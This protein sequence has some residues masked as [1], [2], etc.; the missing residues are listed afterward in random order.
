MYVYIREAAIEPH[1][2]TKAHL[3]PC[4]FRT[5]RREARH[6]IEVQLTSHTRVE[7]KCNSLR[8]IAAVFK[9]SNFCCK[10]ISVSRLVRKKHRVLLLFLRGLSEKFSRGSARI[11]LLFNRPEDSTGCWRDFSEHNILN[12]YVELLLKLSIANYYC[13]LLLALFFQNSEI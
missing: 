5:L 6:R 8:D 12:Y 4:Y 2:A 10:Y 13:K 9:R 3:R 7:A 1:E 11:P